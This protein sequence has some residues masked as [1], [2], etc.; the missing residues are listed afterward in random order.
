MLENLQ[1]LFINKHGNY[2]KLLQFEVIFI[3]IDIIIFFNYFFKNSYGFVIILLIFAIFIANNYVSVKDSTV[4]DF[5]H[6]TILKL[7]TLQSK[8]NDYIN[9]KLNLISNTNSKQ[10]LSPTDTQKIY[11][12]NELDSLY[13]DSNLIHFLYSILPLYEY[14]NYEFYMLL[15]ATNN[16][17]KIRK[18]IETYYDE[19]KDY[20]LN[21][22][23]M[24]E[25]SLKLRAN[26]INNVHNFI[27]TAPKVNK[28]YTYLNDIIDRYATLISR[29]TDS[30]NQYYKDNLNLHGFNSSSKVV[31]YNTTKPYDATQNHSLIPNKYIKENGSLSFYV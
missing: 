15:K 14:N 31:S 5:N 18:Q 13:I 12:N 9:S 2:A 21:I 6:I 30:I 24:F 1:N 10:K 4:N 8:T 27:Y 26:A 23:E 20:P 16:I 11:K 7:N 22:A 3:I 17:L 28:M 19:N 25:E 29:N